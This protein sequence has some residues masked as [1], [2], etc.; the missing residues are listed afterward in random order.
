[1]YTAEASTAQ[2]HDRTASAIHGGAENNS[3]DRDGSDAVLIV[4]DGEHYAPQ[5][6]KIKEKKK[7]KNNKWLH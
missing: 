3:S 4:G 2:S 7:M 6:Q 5:A 1:M